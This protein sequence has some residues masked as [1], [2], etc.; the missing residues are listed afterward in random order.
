MA[1]SRVETQEI[2]MD[3]MARTTSTST[4][5]VMLTIIHY[6]D[7]AVVVSGSN[8][9]IIDEKLCTVNTKHP[10]AAGQLSAAVAAL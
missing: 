1:Y 7:R 9:I 4:A 6:V 2:M 5:V 10:E 8:M 3:S